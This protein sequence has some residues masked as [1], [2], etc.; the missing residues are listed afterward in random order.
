[1]LRFELAEHRQIGLAGRQRP[2]HV[3]DAE[4][5]VGTQLAVVLK[6]GHGTAAVQ[7]RQLEYLAA[8]DRERH[9]GAAARACHVS[10]PALSTAIRA[11]ER[12]LGVPLVRRSG[13]FEGFT[14]EG[15]RVL[16][17]ARRALTDVQS[18][19]QEVDRLRSG[20][21][22]TLRIG[23]IPTALTASSLV[24]SRFRHEHPRMRVQLWSM[25]SREIAHGLEH[26]ELDAIETIAAILGLTWNL[27]FD[28]GN[29]ISM[30]LG[31]VDTELRGYQEPS[32]ALLVSPRCPLYIAGLGGRYRFRKRPAGSSNEYE[33]L[34][35]KAHPWSDIQ[36]AGQ[37]MIGGIRGRGLMLGVELTAEVGHDVVAAA[38]GQGLII[39][40]PR[41][42][43][44]RLVP[45]LIIGDAEVAEFGER[46]RDALAMVEA[47]IEG[48]DA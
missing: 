33:D 4:P 22:G 3:G 25:T 18:L 17:W 39:N 48:G 36:D 19:N 44:I 15:E 32:S 6:L 27:P 23:A 46:F 21:E 29:E 28:G 2:L 24:T 7:L 11:L 13:R 37:Y 31:A 8:L 43:T 20:L 45:P 40:S 35:E 10:Q 30:R 26:G 38:L 41:E 1:M 42:D 34:P 9:F 12:E 47:T 14:E 5:A 16:V